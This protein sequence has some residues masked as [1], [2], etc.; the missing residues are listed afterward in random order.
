MKIKSKPHIVK[1]AQPKSD[2]GQENESGQNRQ[3]DSKDSDL[4]THELRQA[5]RERQRLKAAEYTA[6]D[7]VKTHLK[8][9]GELVGRRIAH[10]QRKNP[11]K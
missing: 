7:P 1:R 6:R 4:S 5:I 9:R 8:Q 10:Y 3:T 11:G 2:A